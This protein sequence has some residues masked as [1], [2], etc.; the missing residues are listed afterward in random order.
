MQSTTCSRSATT[1]GKWD[2]TPGNPNTKVVTG[3]RF[4]RS[5]PFQTKMDQKDPPN[6]VFALN[7]TFSGVGAELDIH[8]GRGGVPATPFPG[9]PHRESWNGTT[10]PHIKTF[11][12]MK[13]L[14]TWLRLDAS[15]TPSILGIPFPSARRLTASLIIRRT[16]R[17]GRTRPAG[18]ILIPFLHL[19]API[20]QT[21]LLCPPPAMQLQTRCPP[22]WGLMPFSW[23]HWILVK[24][25]A[26]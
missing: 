9:T 14:M 5:A 19:L 10:C 11:Q 1:S 17:I 6:L 18:S 23:I 24:C 25:T 12:V 4:K 20:R 26:R 3:H 16:L 21:L 7:N 13:K 22:L 2:P 8:S 15:K